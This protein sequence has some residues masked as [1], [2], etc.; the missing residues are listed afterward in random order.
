MAQGF[1][2]EIRVSNLYNGKHLKFFEILIEKHAY[3]TAHSAMT[4]LFL[5]R[6]SMN[7]SVDLSTVNVSKKSARESS[8]LSLTYV[9][10]VLRISAVDVY[11]QFA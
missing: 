10:R 4:H 8:G 5:D 7:A 2:S 3:S 6:R 9:P 11:V 1:R